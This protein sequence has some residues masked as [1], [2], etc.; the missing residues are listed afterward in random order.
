MQATVGRVIFRVLLRYV[1]F[2]LQSNDDNNYVIVVERL[3]F[4]LL[5]YDLS[6]NEQFNKIQKI[7][8]FGLGSYCFVKV[9]KAFHPSKI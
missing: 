1:T 7:K 2:P 9:S 3:L 8:T 6:F 5:V 4:S